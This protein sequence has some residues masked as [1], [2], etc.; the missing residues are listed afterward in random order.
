[1]ADLAFDGLLSYLKEEL[2]GFEFFTFNYLQMKDLGLEFRL[3]NAKDAHNT[4]RSIHV[5][6]KFDSD[7]EKKEVAELIWPSEAKPYSCSSLKPIPKNRQEQARFTF[8]VSKC[9]LA[10]L[11]NYLEVET[12]SYLMPYR[13]LRS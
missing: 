11:M 5:D 6:Y 13:R 7:N 12:S 9:D 3:Q 8:D 10:Y 4:H 2:K 1:M